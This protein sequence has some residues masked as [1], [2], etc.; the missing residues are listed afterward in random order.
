MDKQ[1]PDILM[2]L[3]QDGKISKK[4][5]RVIANIAEET[6]TDHLSGNMIEVK[7]DDVQYLDGSTMLEY[8]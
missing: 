1:R 7:A 5:N 4:T 3:I 8:T 6:L 2:S